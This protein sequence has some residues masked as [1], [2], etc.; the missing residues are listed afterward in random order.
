[1][2]TS[3]EY[4]SQP[5]AARS[6]PT[7]C[8][9][10]LSPSLSLSLKSIT[11]LLLPLFPSLSVFPLC[12]SLL[13]SLWISILVPVCL[14]QSFSLCSNMSQPFSLSLS[15]SLSVVVCLNHSPSLSLSLCMSLSMSLG[16]APSAPLPLPLSLS[17]SLSL[18]SRGIFCF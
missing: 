4:W 18:F 3:P 7:H 16:M 14:S 11:S 8:P 10:L 2:P 5:A 6:L 1:M 13:V 17:P 15:L 12:L 9:H